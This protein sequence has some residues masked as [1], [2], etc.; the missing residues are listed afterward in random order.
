[1]ESITEP[2][3][4]FIAQNTKV[5]SSVASIASVGNDTRL[6]QKEY[7]SQDALPYRIYDAV[8]GKTRTPTNT[9]VAESERS[10]QDAKK[11]L[12]STGPYPEQKLQNRIYALRELAENNSAMRNELKKICTK[13]EG[14]RELEDN[15]VVEGLVYKT[16]VA[17][18]LSASI[19]GPAAYGSGLVG[20]T[21]A[22][23]AMTYQKRDKEDQL[24]T[25][26]A[27]LD[28]GSIQMYKVLLKHMAD[29]YEEQ[30]K[31]PASKLDIAKKEYLQAAVRASEKAYKIK[32]LEWLFNDVLITMTAYPKEKDPAHLEKRKSRI[33][34]IIEEETPI[35]IKSGKIHLVEKEEKVLKVF[36]RK[37]DEI[38]QGEIADPGPNRK[39]KKTLENT[40]RNEWLEA[41]NKVLEKESAILTGYVKSLV[42]GDEKIPLF[43]RKIAGVDPQTLKMRMSLGKEKQEPS[44]EALDTP[45]PSH[46]GN[47]LPDPKTGP[48]SSSRSTYWSTLK[49]LLI[50]P[51]EQHKERI[52]KAEALINM[53]GHYLEN[54]EKCEGICQAGIQQ[55][56]LR[57]ND[58]H[59]LKAL[60]DKF[61]GLVSRVEDKLSDLSKHIKAVEQ[62]SRAPG[63]Q[64]NRKKQE[65]YKELI[66]EYKWVKGE[67]EKIINKHEAA[68]EF[69][70]KF[71]RTAPKF[72]SNPVPTIASSVS[73]AETTSEPSSMTTESFVAQIAQSGSKLSE[74]EFLTSNP[75]SVEEEETQSTSP[76]NIYNTW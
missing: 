21:A 35:K 55:K 19:V 10:V 76:V 54:L 12:H 62:L 33:E 1:M 50:D 41:R 24:K 42:T 68:G 23:W 65:E 14:L 52:N 64:F 53:A 45:K 56:R 39:V 51:I 61:S 73:T 3:K 58:V 46:Q 70:E 13:L 66:K 27:A 44:L 49:S 48:S 31:E 9:L 5:A 57:S 18:G 8:M 29:K 47:S 74:K 69:L 36:S 63:N 28:E 43:R 7:D 67:Y 30:L 40:V 72:T 4:N 25:T 15:S 6:S 22:D 20:F 2:V 34:A 38:M 59:A 32:D 75:P 17:A 60:H 26:T 11:V 37:T 16:L 71:K